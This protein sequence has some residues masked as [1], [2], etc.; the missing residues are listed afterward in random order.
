VSEKDK[1]EE[2]TVILVYDV[3]SPRGGRVQTLRMGPVPASEVSELRKILLQKR[4]V[5]CVNVEW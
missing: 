3:I 1:E 2:K 5:L 4:N